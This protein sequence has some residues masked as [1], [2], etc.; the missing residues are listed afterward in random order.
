M[1]V[2]VHQ[3]KGAYLTK[4]QAE[5]M[6]DKNPD[7][8]GFAYINH[9]GDITTRKSMSFPT[10]WRDFE[11]ARSKN[12]DSDFVIHFRIA[13]SGKIGIA[14]SHPFK[15]DQFTVMAHNG[16][17]NHITGNISLE[18]EFSDTRVFIRDVLSELPHNWLDRP[19]LRDMVEDY[20]GYSKLTFLTV[21]PG[22]E[23]NIYILN[24]AKGDVVDKMWVSNKNWK[25]IPPRPTVTYVSKAKET[26]K[27]AEMYKFPLPSENN[28][29]KDLE[30][31]QKRQQVI[32]FWEG[33][34]HED[35][36]VI[37]STPKL[38]EPDQQLMKE[39]L[40]LRREVHN[41]TTEILLDPVSDEFE[42]Q[43][44]FTSID[45]ESMECECWDLLCIACGSLAPYCVHDPEDAEFYKVGEAH[46]AY[47]DK[48]G[49][50][51]QRKETNPDPL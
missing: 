44:C 9:R 40:D 49:S 34:T 48:V 6:W 11:K 22:L 15:I 42:C 28:I 16:M 21:D 50:K 20:I 35:G 30:D 19:A 12:R 45:L 17:L 46:K 32:D 25:P 39:I 33:V 38:S 2:I 18:D 47:L 13:T 14:N 23:R 7:G 51:S 5:Q 1:C 26:T 43:T 37:E 8:G 4:E 10:W 3:P 27:L 24:E 41:L 31:L 29:L 36:W